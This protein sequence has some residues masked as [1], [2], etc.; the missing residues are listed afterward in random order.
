M[1]VVRDIFQ[2]KYGRGGKLVALFKEVLP[3][4]GQNFNARILT[5]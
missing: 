4:W 1:I 5:Q 2:A 3:A